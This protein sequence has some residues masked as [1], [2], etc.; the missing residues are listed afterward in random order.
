MKELH[1][2]LGENIGQI[3]LDIASEAVSK[4]DINKAISTYTES[5]ID[6]PE[7]YIKKLLKNECVLK[8]SEDGQTLD[9]STNIE[10]IKENAKY[11]RE[12]YAIFS[13]SADYLTDIVKRIWELKRDLNKIGV[14]ITDFNIMK[15]DSSYKAEINIAAKLISGQDFANLRSNGE[16]V[17]DKLISN[18]EFGEGTKEETTLYSIVTYVDLIRKLHKQYLETYRLYKAIKHFE[19]IDKYAFIELIWERSLELL[20][21]FYDDTKGYYH[22]LCNEKLHELKEQ[23]LED[24]I[25]TEAGRDYQLYN[26]LTKNPTDHYDAAWISPEGEFYGALGETSQMLHYNL[27]EIL[28]EKK[29]KDEV[30]EYG[31]DA[32]RYLCDH[33]WIKVHGNEAY[34]YL[35]YNREHAK[36][37]GRLFAPTRKQIDAICTYMDKWHNGKFYTEF[38]G[39]GPRFKHVDPYSTRDIKQMD[40]LALRNAFK[41]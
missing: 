31:E 9:L 4:G 33:S 24:V 36:E 13:E 20:K 17:W 12:W 8:T 40:E 26:I 7:D 21:E 28:A 23:I 10:D 25:K 22:P 39:I 16:N 11:L 30:R 41:M 6:F 3:L 29:L 14:D 32:E 1:F 37:T 18:Y 35:A 38:A 2:T 5:L 27:A 34:T 19:L 15:L